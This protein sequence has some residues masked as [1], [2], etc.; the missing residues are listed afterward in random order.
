MAKFNAKNT[1]GTTNDVNVAGAPGFK[2]TSFKQEIATVV[3]NSML[4]GD[5]YYEKE[6]ERINKIIN[7][8]TSKEAEPEFLAKAM[9]YTRTVG[10]LR[11]VSHLMGVILAERAKGTDFLR[12]AL[13]KAIV[14]PDDATEMVALFSTRNGNALIPNSL[15]R[16]VKDSL[17]TK[18][19]E[20]Q[21]KKYLGG[22]NK[23]KLKDIVKLAHPNPVELVKTGKAKDPFVFKRVIEGTL[24]NIDTAQTVNAG[25]TGVER[26]TSYKKMLSEKKL[27][28]MAAL[29]NIKNILDANA[30]DATVDMLCELLRNERAVR[31]SKV[32][33]FR[34]LQ[35]YDIVDRLNINRIT[36]KKVLK[37]VE[38]GFIL[39]AKNVPI[40]EEGES[41]AILLD[42]SGSMGWSSKHNGMSAFDIGKTLMASMLTGLDKELTVGY[43][44]A[45]RAREIDVN[46]SPFTFI[47]NTHTQGGGTDITSALKKMTSTKTKVDKV[48]I[49]TDMQHNSL[50]G[51][52]QYL[53]DYRRTVNPGVKVL[54]WNVEGY[55]GATPVKMSKDIM[56]I[57]GYSDNLLEV[58]AKM[59]KFSDP[60][61]LIKEIE[62][63][64]L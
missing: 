22:S 5:S 8:M 32:L 37:A 41:V 6:S 14:R 25:S 49:I 36:V 56:E 16:A 15:R 47:K 52:D 3:L 18:W 2:R 50:R 23:V 64:E 26:A 28:Y 58:A 12:S 24:A 48:V 38:D 63:V 7:M 17:E 1:V 20:Y 44:W 34:F 30:D 46:G 45:D 21:L 39:S 10:N 11:S 59:L 60:D 40:V 19:D 54:F 55:G 4:N 43:L 51:V 33:P 42:E 9:V 31:N 62:A 35:A 61:Y 29:K 57:S 27:G 13:G 53:N